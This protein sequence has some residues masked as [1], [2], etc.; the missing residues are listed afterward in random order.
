MGN[1]LMHIM[2]TFLFT[3]LYAEQISDHEW[4]KQVSRKNA[5]WFKNCEIESLSRLRTILTNN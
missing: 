3:L 4:S 2:V 5:A 1:Y